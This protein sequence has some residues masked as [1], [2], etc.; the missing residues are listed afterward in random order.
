V[1]ESNHKDGQAKVRITQ[2]DDYID[3]VVD[4]PGKKTGRPLTGKELEFAQKMREYTEFWE[5]WEKENANNPNAERPKDAPR[6]P[7]RREPP[8]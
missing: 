1:S 4:G 2:Y 7:L 6:H 8:T 3:I 5:K